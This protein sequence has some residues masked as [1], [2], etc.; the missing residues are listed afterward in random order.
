MEFKKTTACFTKNDRS[1]YQ[2]RRVVF[3]P[4]TGRFFFDYFFLSRIAGKR[5][6]QRSQ[7]N[8]KTPFFSTTFAKRTF[9]SSGVNHKK[10]CIS[11][12]KWSKKGAFFPFSLIFRT[13]IEKKQQNNFANHRILLTFGVKIHH[14]HT[15][16]SRTA[17]AVGV[18]SINPCLSQHNTIIY[19]LCHS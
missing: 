8:T 12:Q 13:N 1:F 9:Q 18:F 6:E 2:K 7:Q 10:L 19:S 3:I 15:Q 11:P 16:S 17:C 4:S 14:S 5:H